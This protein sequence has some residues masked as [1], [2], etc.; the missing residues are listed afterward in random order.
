MF[1]CIQ[2]LSTK[3]NNFFKVV[4]GI[5]SYTPL[6]VET[7]LQTLGVI[8]LPCHQLICVISHNSMHHC[9]Y[10]RETGELLKNPLAGKGEDGPGALL[11]LRA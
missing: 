8:W 4:K 2:G 7:H 9:L 10:Y 6:I 3:E 5:I 1:H 11:M